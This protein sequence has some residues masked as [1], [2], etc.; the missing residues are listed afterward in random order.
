MH[1]DLTPTQI[2]TVVNGLNALN[3]ENSDLINEIV[4]QYNALN[5]P[6]VPSEAP[7]EVLADGD[8]TPQS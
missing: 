3:K 5:T 2:Q 1:I 4:R 8:G 7:S 6:P